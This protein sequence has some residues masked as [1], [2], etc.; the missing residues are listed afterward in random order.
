V[1]NIITTSFDH[2]AILVSLESCS[3]FAQELPVQHGFKFEAMW[4]HAPDYK[5]VL[6]KAWSDGSC[7]VRSLHDTWSNL[8]RVA[9]S[10]RDWSRAT[11][12]SV[13]KN[14]RKLEGRLRYIRGQPFSDLSLKEEREV[15]RE[16]CEL[17][18]REEIMARQRSRVEWLREG[19]RNT[20]FFHARA[21]ARRRTNKIDMLLREDGSRCETQGEIKGM[22]H[23][24]YENLFTSEMCASSD[25]VL[26][27]IP[28]KVTAKMN[29]DLCKPYTDEEIGAALFQMGPTKAPGPDGFPALF[30]QTHWDFFKEE[31]CNAVRSFISGGEVP[32]GFCDSVIVLIPKVTKAKHLKNF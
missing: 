15:E 11:F 3:R 16:L 24:F 17:F 22:I 28:P 1:E 18:E 19:D 7:G 30:Y 10:L 14:I 5:E 21:S 9:G 26:N 2:Y 25:A 32:E 29:D 31:I 27:A 8:G 4:L 6:E 12:G 20:A 23:N 13:R